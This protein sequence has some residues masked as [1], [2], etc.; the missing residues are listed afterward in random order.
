[1]LGRIARV[2]GQRTFRIDVER[3]LD[4]LDIGNRR[5]ARKFTRQTMNGGDAPLL[6]P[7]ISMQPVFASS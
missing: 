6:K 7:Y 3:Q 2:A 4:H 5:I 1:M